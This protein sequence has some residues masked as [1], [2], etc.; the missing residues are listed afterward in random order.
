MSIKLIKIKKILTMTTI[1]IFIVFIVAILS[2]SLNKPKKVMAS[3]KIVS[4]S[5]IASSS[6]AISSSSLISVPSVNPSNYNRIKTLQEASKIN[7]D[8]VGWL[9]APGTTLNLPIVQT[10]N[11]NYYLKKSI[12]KNYAWKGWPFADFNDVFDPLPKNLIIYGHNMGDGDLFGQLKK[13]KTLSFLNSNP[14]LYFSTSSEECYWKI[15]AVYITDTNF[16]YIQTNFK[17]DEKFMSFIFKNKVRSLFNTSVDV[18]A[19]DSILTLSTCTYEFHDARFVV[20]A[21]LVRTGE[22]QSVTPAT[23][24]PKPLSPH[25]KAT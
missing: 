15:F 19:S 11:N 14:V 17:N 2:S 21:R 22:S 18:V 9:Y 16:N 1:F 24:N 5:S 8:T 3:L 25:N 12:Y 20:M 4:S 23:V 10:K 13:F 7:S 6:Q